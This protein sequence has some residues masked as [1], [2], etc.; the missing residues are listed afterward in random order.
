MGTE[1]EADRT[2]GV[3]ADGQDWRR[4]LGSL[5]ANAGE[6][7]GLILTEGK[8]LVAADPPGSRRAIEVARL[9]I[10]FERV[11]CGLRRTAMLDDRLGKPAPASGAHPARSRAAARR[12][13][14]RSVEDVIQRE[15]EGHRAA[16]L[17][18]ELAE[19]LD[20]P[21]LEDEIADRPVAEIVADICRDLGLTAAP[22]T[23]PWKRRTPAEVAALCERAARPAGMGTAAVGRGGMGADGMGADGM[24]ADGMGAD[25][26]G[27]DGVGAGGMGAGG[28]GAGGMGAGGM[29][30][31][32]MGAGGMGAGG[33]GAGGMGAGGMGAD[34]MEADRM[35]AEG[36]G[37][38]RTAGDRVPPGTRRSD[39]VA[40]DGMARD[41]TAAD[42]GGADGGGADHES[43]DGGGADRESADGRDADTK[44]PDARQAG[45]TAPDRAGEAASAASG[46]GV[47]AAAGP[48]P[49]RPP[50]SRQGGAPPAA[51]D[52]PPAWVE[53][54]CLPEEEVWPDMPAGGAAP[55]ESVDRPG[56][57]LAPNP[58][59]RFGPALG[60]GSGAARHEPPQWR[61]PLWQGWASR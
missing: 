54:D 31:D 6:M 61:P 60:P 5:G 23:R 9:G 29:G 3:A 40:P 52:D 36:R 8:A 42:G 16:A 35:E 17:A 57:R 12:R 11:A 7:A 21:D 10:A 1:R 50:G 24:G 48:V 58:G 49:G 47:Q 51:R 59:P 43:A 13:I 27:A 39:G 20:S 22:G 26:M 45:L 56:C 44:G 32:G 4:L 2:A 28:M 14:I 41:E 38:D 30:A 53:Q 37:R 55:P 15:A 33:M 34:R 19:R 18:G 25:G 46:R